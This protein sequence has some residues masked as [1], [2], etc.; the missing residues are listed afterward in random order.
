MGGGIIG[1]EMAEVYHA[2]GSR[3][4]V[5]ETMGKIIRSASC[6][7][8]ACLTPALCRPSHRFPVSP[9]SRAGCFGSWLSLP[10]DRVKGQSRVTS[11]RMTRAFFIPRIGLCDSSSISRPSGSDIAASKRS[12][13]CAP[14]KR[15]IPAAA[16][17]VCPIS[18]ELARSLRSLPA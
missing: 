14:E 12:R 11:D 6:S 13:L 15:S 8:S 4:T 9:G 2:L 7:I 16:R 1:L 10:T 3:L 17:M 5:V 18:S